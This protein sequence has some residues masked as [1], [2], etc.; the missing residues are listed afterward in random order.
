MENLYKQCNQY[1]SLPILSHLM[2]KHEH[3]VSGFVPWCL[4]LMMWGTGFQ[5]AIMRVSPPSPNGY[6]FTCLLY[7]M[8]PGVTAPLT[9]SSPVKALIRAECDLVRDEP[10]AAHSVSGFY[11]YLGFLCLYRY[12]FPPNST[13]G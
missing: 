1:S 10:V 11:A 8:L 12:T 3:G 9:H 6:L 4:A 2:Y 7:H 13:D 5:C